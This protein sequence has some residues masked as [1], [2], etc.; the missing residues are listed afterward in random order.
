VQDIISQPPKV[1]IIR[2]HL[3]HHGVILHLFCGQ[4]FKPISGTSHISDTSLACITMDWSN[5]EI[6]SLNLFPTKFLLFISA[7]RHIMMQCKEQPHP[8]A[9]IYS[10]SGAPITF[11]IKQTRRSFW[12]LPG[13]TEKTRKGLQSVQSV[14][15]QSLTRK[16]LRNV[17]S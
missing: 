16:K 8:L 2:Y 4:L 5:N 14:Y 13:R 12:N 7:P 9:I 15:L 1:T 3:S 6:I 17:S 10:I 11:L